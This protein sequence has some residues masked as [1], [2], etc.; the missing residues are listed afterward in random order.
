[1]I[2][3]LG[4][5]FLFPTLAIYAGLQSPT[6]TYTEEHAIDIAENFLKK[7]P[8]Y[9]FDGIEETIEFVKV[10]TIRMPN[11]WLATFKFDSRQS[12]YGDRTGEI[13]LQ[14]ITEHTM[15]IMVSNGEVIS[16]VTDDV[17]DELTETMQ[18]VDIGLDEAEQLALDWLMAAPTF[19]FDGVE[20]SMSIIDT[21][22][23]ESYP[24]QYFVSISFTCAQ[25]GYGDRTDVILAQVLTDHIARV[26]VSNGEV[27]SAVID[28]EW[29]EV[30][31]EMLDDPE[32]LSMEEA[33]KIVTVYLREEYPEA[34][35]LH[36]TSEWGIANLTPE[37][38]LGSTTIEYSGNGW[39]ITINYTVVWKP[40]YSFTVEN[41]SGFTWSGTVDQSGSIVEN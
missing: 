40:T 30:T 34:E 29:N 37:N 11:T 41:T 6:I 13:L 22:I 16:A 7:S 31:Q 38:L 23:A 4:L 36:I 8:T 14:V 17:F 27:R 3:A 24:V 19:S 2:I 5:V 15:A 18:P 12:G 1:M 39:V 21:A 25:P 28:D 35:T 20:N 32:I 9:S 26:V 33:L 10:D